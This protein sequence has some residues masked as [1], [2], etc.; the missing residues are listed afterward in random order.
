MN[1]AK[2]L[3]FSR[4]PRVPRGFRPST[5]GIFRPL[6]PKRLYLPHTPYRARSLK[7]KNPLEAVVALALFA[8]LVFTPRAIDFAEQHPVETGF[9]SAIPIGLVLL[10]VYWKVRRRR[11]RLR[12]L[13]AV[14]LADVDNMPGRR[15]ERYLAAL[16]RH[17]GYHVE[18]T[19]RSGDQGCDLILSKDGERIVSQAKRYHGP[20]SN[21]A[22][23]EAVAAV[24]LYHC[25]RAMVVT[26]SRF[27][28]GAQRLAAANNCELI[29]RERLGALIADFR[30]SAGWN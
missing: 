24:A 11:Q 12:A 23:Q 25:H 22:V 10:A 6:R 17:H 18:E 21:D 28:D 7:F 16:F 9:L 20:V 14:Q 29:D 5:V 3:R 8:A 1:L 26:N 13:K 4:V 19:G 27:T 2:P 15:F 30:K